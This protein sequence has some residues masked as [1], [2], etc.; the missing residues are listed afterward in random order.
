MGGLPKSLRAWLGRIGTKTL[1]I[2][3]GRPCKKPLIAGSFFLRWLLLRCSC[4]LLFQI[5][6]ARVRR[7][8]ALDVIDTSKELKLFS[9]SPWAFP[10]QKAA[11]SF[12]VWHG[13]ISC[14]AVCRK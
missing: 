9:V 1:Y 13:Y 12:D 6:R 11:G 8:K 10:E 5:S 7:R 4:P 3:P 2:Q 14:L